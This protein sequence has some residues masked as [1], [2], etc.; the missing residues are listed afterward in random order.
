MVW[1]DRGERGDSIAPTISFIRWVLSEIRT[2]YFLQGGRVAPSGGYPPL[3]DG[4]DWSVHS[5]PKMAPEWKKHF[6]RL[7]SCD[8]TRHYCTTIYSG[9]GSHSTHM[10]RG[11]YA[12]GEWF[13][14][15]PS[16]CYCVELHWN[17]QTI[18]YSQSTK[19]Y[20]HS[21][22]ARPYAKSHAYLSVV[23]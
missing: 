9:D 12:M 14:M 22:C 4:G 8:E 19:S 13:L 21:T 6:V 15:K 10:R 17:M 5:T 2:I 23:G 1:M 16:L 7:L 18:H 20:L 11:K 3:F